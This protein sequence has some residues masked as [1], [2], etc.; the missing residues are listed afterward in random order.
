MAH[1]VMPPILLA[2]A[3]EV[4][5]CWMDLR[6]MGIPEQV[7]AIK[8]G[9][10]DIGLS[11]PPILDPMM[12][13]EKLLKEPFVAAIPTNNPLARKKTLSVKTLVNAP[14]II[15]PSGALHD[16]IIESCRNAG[17]EPRVIQEAAELQTIL[18]LVS[19]GLGISLVPSS[20]RRVQMPN[21]IYK[22]LVNSPMAET[23][24][25]WKADSQSPLL[26]SFVKV[27]KGTART[28]HRMQQ[29]GRSL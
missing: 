3:D 13:V 9:E 12:H 26:L 2:F 4:P 5:H 23:V 25:V 8:S 27:A 17:F 15:P 29:V 10:I 20:S 22:P 6:Q 18:G 1:T 16:L 24:L 14:F 19:A 11:R 28:L 21:V 7:S